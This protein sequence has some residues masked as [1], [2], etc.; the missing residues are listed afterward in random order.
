MKTTTKPNFKLVGQ[1]GELLVAIGLRSWHVLDESRFFSN[2][3]FLRK[4]FGTDFVAGLF[5]KPQDGVLK[6]ISA[7]TFCMYCKAAWVDLVRDQ[8]LLSYSY[9]YKFEHENGRTHGGGMSG[10]KVNE[11]HGSVSAR[12]AGYCTVE[13]MQISPSGRGRVVEIIDLRVIRQIQ[14]DDKGYLRVQRRKMEIDWYREMPRILE[15][16][17]QNKEGDVKV[18]LV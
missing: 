4:A 13:L 17:E 16:C 2:G 11:F 14:T 9:S 5:K 12:P 6:T 15:F 1:N 7:F 18:M 10:F 3:A 8:D